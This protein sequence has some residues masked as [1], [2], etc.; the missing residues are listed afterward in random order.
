MKT[1]NNSKD[2]ANNEDYQAI[3]SVLKKNCSFRHPGN[4][5][6]KIPWFLKNCRK[7]SVSEI[8]TKLLNDSNFM[9]D[10]FLDK[11]TKFIIL[12][13]K[14]KS[15]RITKIEFLIKQNEQIRERLQQILQSDGKSRGKITLLES[16]SEYGPVSITLEIGGEVRN[17]E[18]GENIE[19]PV[20]LKKNIEIKVFVQVKDLTVKLDEIYVSFDSVLDNYNYLEITDEPFFKN[21]LEKG[22]ERYK[23]KLE[24]DLFLSN[25]DRRET[26][27]IHL[28]ENEKC[29][30]QEN[31]ALDLFMELMNQLAIKEV[32]G[33]FES[34]FEPFKNRDCCA[35]QVL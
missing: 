3:Y 7:K 26:L 14:E 2:S 10:D 35:C 6:P 19:G 21:I 25:F 28:H 22:D 18:D 24:I 13:I 31:E 32:D 30:E 12:G 4:N 8:L 11:T 27:N 1:K 5:L 20:A 16:K 29:Y 34:I 15:N 17:L 23:I 33:E 9:T